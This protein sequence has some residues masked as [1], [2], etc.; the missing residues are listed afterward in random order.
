M[1]PQDRLSKRIV[2]GALLVSGVFV[3]AS[4]GWAQQKHT[5]S[6]SKSTRDSQYTQEHTIDVGDLPGH[7]VRIFE[8]HWNYAKGE[9]AFDGVNV[10]ESWVR[11]PSDYTNTSGPAM[12]NIIY[13][14]EDGNKVFSRNAVATQDHRRRRWD[15]DCEVFRG[16][17]PVRRHWQVQPHSRSVTPERQPR[18]GSKRVDAGSKRRLLVRGVTATARQ[19]PTFQSFI[20][21]GNHHEE[22]SCFDVSCVARNGRSVDQS[23]RRW[24]RR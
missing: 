20:H 24:C 17:D 11:G 2:A 4:A 1:K 3:A 14:L 18:A 19:D 5:V 15:Q 16:R 10:K 22:S 9:L 12:N 21:K 13:V 8:I 23:C 7:K 6:Y